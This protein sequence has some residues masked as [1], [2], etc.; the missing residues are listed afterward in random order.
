MGQWVE[1]STATKVKGGTGGWD[2]K[3]IFYEAWQRVKSRCHVFPHSS[4][5]LIT[6][7][8]HP[9]VIRFAARTHGT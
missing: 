1:P 5:G 2:D 4:M 8:R 9:F 7:V 3:V 6:V